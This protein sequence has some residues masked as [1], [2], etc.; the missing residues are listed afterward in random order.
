MMMSVSFFYKQ[1]IRRH[2]DAKAALAQWSVD[3]VQ[4]DYT[5]IDAAWPV[6]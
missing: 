2:R 4:D 5:F 3:L 6:S 1:L